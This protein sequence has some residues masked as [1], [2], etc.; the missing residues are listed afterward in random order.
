MP[1]AMTYTRCPLCK[2][3]LIVFGVSNTQDSPHP[4]RH[5][6]PCTRGKTPGWAVTGV[7]LGQLDRL[8]RQ[9][10][11]ALNLERELEIA[12]A[13]ADRLREALRRVLAQ[14]RVDDMEEIAREALE[15]DA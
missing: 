1:S 10:G 5:P 12:R 9:E 15:A 3:E 14:T 6:C 8:S 7:T 13:E 4:R 2:G 11:K